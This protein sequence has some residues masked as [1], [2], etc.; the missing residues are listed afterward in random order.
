MHN[1]LLIVFAVLVI[2]ALVG[3]LIFKKTFSNQIKL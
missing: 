1:I 2:A 3:S